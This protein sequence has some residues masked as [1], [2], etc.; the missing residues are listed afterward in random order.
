MEPE[1]FTTTKIEDFNNLLME[2]RDV[3]VSHT[4]F[5]NATRETLDLIQQGNYILVVDE[6]LDIIQDFNKLNFVETNVRQTV[7]EGDI[8]MLISWIAQDVLPA[9]HG[10]SITVTI[11]IASLI[12]PDIFYIKRDTHMTIH[13][14]KYRAIR[15][16]HD[17][18]QF[19]RSFLIQNSGGA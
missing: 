16:R 12:V 11:H 10:A 2:G 6:A 5:L 1:N 19:R 9:P 7:S 8:T 4:T 18:G 13:G 15:F 3:A 17:T 14:G